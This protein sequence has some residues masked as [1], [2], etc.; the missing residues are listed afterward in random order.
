MIRVSCCEPESALWLCNLH[1]FLGT[2]FFVKH[3]VTEQIAFWVWIIRLKLEIL[4]Y[5]LFLS[6]ESTVRP[7]IFSMWKGHYLSLSPWILIDLCLCFCCGCVGDRRGLQLLASPIS[8][9]HSLRLEFRWE[10]LWPTGRSFILLHF[11]L[12]KS[13]K[14]FSVLV[15]VPYTW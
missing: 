11:L 9:S 14:F 4:S 10:S 2:L 7:F 5:V 13:H 6:N 12:F 8:M 1:G 15:K 3:I